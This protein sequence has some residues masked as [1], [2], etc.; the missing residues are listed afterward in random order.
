MPPKSPFGFSPA[1]LK[2]VKRLFGFKLAC[3]IEPN[4]PFGFKA[5]FPDIQRFT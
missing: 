3:F 2:E 5:L 4:R 1:L